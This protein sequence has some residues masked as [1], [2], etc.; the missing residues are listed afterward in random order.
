MMSRNRTALIRS[1]TLNG[2]NDSGSGGPDSM[3]VVDLL[4]NGQVVET[5]RLPG[6]S[7]SYANDVV[8]NWESGLI[9][10]LVD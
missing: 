3:F 2:T 5:R 9:Q 10:L 6:K 4:E 1:E 7:R 8:E